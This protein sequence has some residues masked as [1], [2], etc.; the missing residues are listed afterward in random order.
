VLVCNGTHKNELLFYSRIV[1]LDPHIPQELSPEAADLITNFLEREGG[2]E[3]GADAI[4]RH[5]FFKVSSFPICYHTVMYKN[6][7]VLN[8]LVH[9]ILATK[10]I[11]RTVSRLSILFLEGFIILK[12]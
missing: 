1:T 10:K 11:K 3:G 5:P 4:K 8:C 9:V 6:V 7:S 2:G 12:L